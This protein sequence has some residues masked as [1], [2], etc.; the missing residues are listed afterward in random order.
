LIE[1]A[2]NNGIN[3]LLACSIVAVFI[4]LTTQL[5]SDSG[6]VLLNSRIRAAG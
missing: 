4:V 3:L 6:Y 5:I 1:A 2:G